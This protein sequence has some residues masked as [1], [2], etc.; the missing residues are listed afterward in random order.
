MSEEIK[1]KTL[2]EIDKEFKSC[3]N[4][5]DAINESSVLQLRYS[6]RQAIR[7]VESCERYFYS[8]KFKEL[9][10]HNS[11]G[12][13]GA[14]IVNIVRQVAI[15]REL[16]TKQPSYSRWREHFTSEHK[17]ED[18][19]I[20][21]AVEKYMNGIEL[22]DRVVNDN[23][24]LIKRTSEKMECHPP[25]YSETKKSFVCKCGTKVKKTDY[26]CYRCGRKL[27][28]TEKEKEMEDNGE[29]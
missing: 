14:E 11:W 3:L 5:V 22:I 20:A 1:E 7:L 13:A 25:T 28:K 29:I 17:R 12:N 8:E 16:A 4:L 24:N 21:I 15:M 18:D 26:Y 27:R 9:N 10:R 6:V 19:D 2:S 23:Y